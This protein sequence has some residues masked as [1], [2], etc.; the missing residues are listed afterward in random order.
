M[1]VN[2]NVFIELNDTNVSYVQKKIM[3]NDNNALG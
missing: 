1:F 2:I 3:Y